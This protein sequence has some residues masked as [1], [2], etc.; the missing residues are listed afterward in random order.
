V[1]RFIVANSYRI[2]EKNGNVYAFNTN[3]RETIQIPRDYRIIHPAGWQIYPSI[4]TMKLT[5]AYKF[6]HKYLQR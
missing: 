4:H 1:F 2:D 5:D 3:K 6:A